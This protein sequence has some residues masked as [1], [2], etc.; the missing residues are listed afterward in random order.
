MAGP[1]KRANT[2]T[3]NK[4]KKTKVLHDKHKNSSKKK[5]IG[6]TSSVK[7]AKF[8]ASGIPLKPS[9]QE[10]PA[11]L[12]KQS[13]QKH[14]LNENLKNKATISPPASIDVNE[15]KKQVLT[16]AVFRMSIQLNLSRSELSSII[17]LSESTLSRTFKESSIYLL[18]PL[19]NEGQLAILLLRIYQSLSALLG[20]KENQCE[21]WL[22][23]ENEHLGGAPI[24]LMKSINGLVLTSQYLEAMR[25]KI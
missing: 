3:S 19:S 15:A 22:R 10:M 17:G 6:K 5:K 14:N 21:L 7:S 11:K 18:D 1:Q 16:K 4:V 12:K 8:S 13:L 20:G 2:T 24:E 25:G 23:S 9:Y